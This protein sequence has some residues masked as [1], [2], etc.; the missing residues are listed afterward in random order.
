MTAHMLYI[1]ER[2]FEP[3]AAFSVPIGGTCEIAGA[4]VRGLEKHGGTLQL[5]AHVDEVLV[6]NGRAAGVRLRN[7]RTLRARKAV[8]SN[9]TPFDTAKLLKRGPAVVVAAAPPA[10][11]PLSPAVAEWTAALNKLPRHG[12]IMHLFVAIDA[13]GLD[14]THLGGD[15]AH[16][17]VQDWAR[18]L[19][20]SQNL[21]SFFIPSLVDPSVCPA[22]THVIHVYSS[23]GEPYEPCAARCPRGPR[24]G[25]RAARRPTPTTARGRSRARAGVRSRLTRRWEALDSDPA[26][27]EAYKRERA[28][29][30]WRAV[31]RAI[32]DV[33]A[34]A[35]FDVIGSPLAHEAFLRRDRGTYGMAWAAGSAAPYAGLLRCARA[36]GA[37]P[38]APRRLARGVWPRLRDSLARRAFPGAVTARAVR[39]HRHVLP[40]PFP[41]MKT[42]LDG[43]LRCGDSCFPGI[44]TPSAAASG[45]IAASTIQPVGK[46]IAMLKE[47]SMRNPVYKFLDPGP[48]G[49]V[50]ELLTAPLT[51]SP[52]L[53]GTASGGGLASGGSSTGSAAAA[54][55]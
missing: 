8:V 32:P 20:D 11:E 17:I 55:E 52:E 1:L 45:A 4:L 53:R 29:V 6:E 31:E 42:P 2:F 22:G 47:A 24:R 35:L 46:H 14:L 30:L 33:R 44:G 41:D 51:P 27:Y 40:F 38:R 12:A 13:Q 15:C 34:R 21:C 37:R 10:A 25:P 50:Y 48:L 5:N 26:K 16:L 9:L 23:G 18:S 7:G 3:D 43:L 54:G 19:Q 28:E 49:S 36:G 39:H